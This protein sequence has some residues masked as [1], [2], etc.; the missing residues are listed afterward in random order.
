[1]LSCRLLWQRASLSSDPVFLAFLAGKINLCREFNLTP[2]TE[3]LLK[4]TPDINSVERST[5][6]QV[7]KRAQC[8]A[9]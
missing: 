3:L 6:A 5:A 1:M 8:L 2:K 7:A 4:Q 9:S